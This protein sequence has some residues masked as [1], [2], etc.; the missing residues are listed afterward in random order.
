MKAQEFFLHQFMQS[1]GIVFKMPVYQRQYNWT[2]ENCK[3]L[4]NDVIAVG[5]SSKDYSHYIGGIVHIYDDVYS[6]SSENRREMLIIDGQQRLITLSLMLIAAYRFLLE[7]G[8]PLKAEEIYDSYLVNKYSR[9]ANNFKL[10][11]TENNMT[12]LKQIMDPEEKDPIQEYSRIIENFRFFQKKITKANI[13]HVLAGFEKLIFIET[14]LERGKDNPQK[15][16]ENL[17]STGL[18]LSEADLIRNYVLMDLRPDEQTALF[19]EYWLPIEKNT[20]S[21]E[22]KAS[23]LPSYIQDFLT[24]KR[25]EVVQKDNV[26]DTFKKLYPHPNSEELIVGLKEIRQYSVPYSRLLN[27]GLEKDPVIRQQLEYMRML[28][29]TIAYPFLICVYLDYQTGLID[30]FTF[31]SVLELIQTYLWRRTLLDLPLFMVKYFFV[32]LYKK[33]DKNDY[34]H[35]LEK[36]IMRLNSKTSQRIPSDDEIREVLKTK[37][38]YN[39]KGSKRAYYFARMENHN[40]KEYVD[41]RLPHITIEHIFPQTP[42]AEWRHLLSK[43]EIRVIENNYLHTIGNLTLSGNNG[44]LSNK[45]FLE[46]R[47]MNEDGGE[48]GYAY[49]RLWFNRDLKVLEKWDLEEIEKRTERFTQRVLEVWSLPDVPMDAEIDETNVFHI[50]DPTYRKLTS[51]SFRGEVKKSDSITSM[52]LDVLQHLFSIDQQ[53]FLTPSMQRK[54]GISI[55]D[56][57]LRAGRLLGDG[58]YIETNMDSRNKIERLKFVLEEFDMESELFLRFEDIE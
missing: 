50:E 29:T 20:F 11:L 52:Y 4:L 41:V 24:I 55:D 13:E 27:P 18:D 58:Y 23:Y 7:V 9:S 38:I 19:N 43:E 21:D 1:K 6:I 31:K 5:S 22:K 15:I 48:Q 40:N 32:K 3:K 25:D 14:A 47:D 54:L 33:I 42:S 2:Q 34:I 56:T 53:R 10:H 51:Y 17:N 26:Y 45:T 46:K 28:D 39:L 12:A 35:S 36:I 44:S 49:S 30:K 37:D 57:L 16:Y 8:D